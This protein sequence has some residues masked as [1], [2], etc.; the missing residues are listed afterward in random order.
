MAKNAYQL[1]DIGKSA[2]L[3]CCH[4]KGNTQKLL[5]DRIKIESNIFR[6]LIAISIRIISI[7]QPDLMDG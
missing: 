7:S 2:K 1:K 6:D 4:I 3:C 5:K